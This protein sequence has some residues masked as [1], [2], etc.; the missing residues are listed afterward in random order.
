MNEEQP[1]SPAQVAQSATHGGD[2]D[3]QI[4]A[5]DA[6]IRTLERQLAEGPRS[7]LTFRELRNDLAIEAELA[8]AREKRGAL[9]YDRDFAK[10][11]A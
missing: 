9:I 6:T 4:D 2:L 10:R 3:H 7:R 5:Q 1:S 11:Q 8:T